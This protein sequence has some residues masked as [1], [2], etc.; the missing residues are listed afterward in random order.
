MIV[1]ML[2]LCNIWL[3]LLNSILARLGCVALFIFISQSAQLAV[4][5]S[6]LFSPVHESLEPSRIFYESLVSSLLIVINPAPH[7]AHFAPYCL[8]ECSIKLVKMMNRTVED[9]KMTEKAVEHEGGS[10]NK[11]NSQI[12]LHFKSGLP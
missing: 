9:S 2:F 7:Q 3:L 11:M 5:F 6:L 1:F 12:T 8:K 4:F 10:S